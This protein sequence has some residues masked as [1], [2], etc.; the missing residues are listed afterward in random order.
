VQYHIVQK[1]S[2]K[3]IKK[4]T[5]GYY[6]YDTWREM[7]SIQTIQR[8]YHRILSLTTLCCIQLHFNLRI[9]Q[10]KVDLLSH[11][12]SKLTSDTYYYLQHQPKPYSV[13]DKA[14]AREWG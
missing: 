4:D 1:I 7:P 8:I 12:K 11:Y 13:L 6:V 9:S 14:F 2:Q 3:K 10:S 5:E